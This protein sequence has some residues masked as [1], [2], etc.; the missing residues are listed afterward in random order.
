LLILSTTAGL[1]TVSCLASG[2]LWLLAEDME[3]R[4]QPAAAE[5]SKAMAIEASETAVERS[6]IAFLPTA[7]PNCG[8][9]THQWN[10]RWYH[11]E[12]DPPC[13][14]RRRCLCQLCCCPAEEVR[15]K[16]LRINDTPNH[17]L[18]PEQRKRA[19]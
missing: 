19:S 17:K 2:I 9:D 7:C 13:I 15:V 11:N 14:R 4:R 18:I 1:L 6:M 12:E 8:D 10:H 3:R 16:P 5:G